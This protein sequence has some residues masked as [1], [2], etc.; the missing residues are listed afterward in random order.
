M[1]DSAAEF[2]RD[3]DIDD[4]RDIKWAHPLLEDVYA[5]SGI[6]D[7]VA[8]LLDPNNP[9]EVVQSFRNNFLNTVVE[10]GEAFMSESHR[11][12]RNAGT[13]AEHT[14]PGL[15]ES[16]P[17]IRLRIWMPNERKKKRL[18]ALFQIHGGGLANGSIDM[19]ESEAMFLCRDGDCAL[20]STSFRWAPDAQY[21]AQLDDI[22]ASYQWLVDNGAE[23]GLNPKRIILTGASSGGLLALSFAFRIKRLGLQK[24]RGAIIFWPPIDD[25]QSTNSSRYKT[26]MLDHLGYRRMFNALLGELS[27]RSDVGPEAVPGH[28]RPEDYVGLCPMAIH[29]CEQDVDRDDVFRFVQ[30]L[31]NAGVY[32][33]FKLWPGAGHLSI[34]AATGDMRDRFE[35]LARGSLSDFIEYDLARHWLVDTT[36]EG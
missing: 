29:C 12:I 27:G 9:L 8:F 14:I 26:N 4:R 20:V 11:E 18:P 10:A 5:T 24:P 2:W 23:L 33:D 17:D 3:E 32:C 19:N 31:L 7:T 25:R 34:G 22:T 36:A 35:V 21:P 16:D 13:F 6:E 30:S 1:G 15:N 28:A